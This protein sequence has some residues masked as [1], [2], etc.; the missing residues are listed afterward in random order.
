MLVGALMGCDGTD[1]AGNACPEYGVGSICTI[2]GTV[3]DAATGDP[4]E[5]IEVAAPAYG[6]ETPTDVEGAFELWLYGCGHKVRLTTR[7]HDG[8]ANGG[9]YAPETIDVYTRFVEYGP[10]VDQKKQVG[11]PTLEL[12]PLHTEPVDDLP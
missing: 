2:E 11:R 8:A 6:D 5:G 1:T 7:D 10:C 4:I 9:H 12:R 3:V